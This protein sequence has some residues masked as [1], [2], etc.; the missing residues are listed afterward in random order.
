MCR[1]VKDDSG[2]EE[3]EDGGCSLEA[4]GVWAAGGGGG[5]AA[6]AAGGGGDIDEFCC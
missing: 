2:K 3:V 5:A 4:A 1:R 6:A